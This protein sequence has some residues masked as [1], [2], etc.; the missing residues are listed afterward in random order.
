MERQKI[1][2]DAIQ[3]LEQE[4]PEIEIQADKGRILRETAFNESCVR[5]VF[6]GFEIPDFP[7]AEIT[8]LFPS[9]HDWHLSNNLNTEIKHGVNHE[10]VLENPD[11]LPLGLFGVKPLITFLLIGFVFTISDFEQGELL[12]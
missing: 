8:K 5:S 4:I 6:H 9:R 10:V 12:L 3:A 7:E 1:Y 2:H 11:H